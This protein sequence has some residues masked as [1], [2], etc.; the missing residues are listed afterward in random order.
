[1]RRK[2]LRVEGPASL[3]HNQETRRRESALVSPRG[4]F[5][6]RRNSLLER[7][8]HPS[9]HGRNGCRVSQSQALPFVQPIAAKKTRKSTREEAPLP[10]PPGWSAGSPPA[11]RRPRKH[12]AGPRARGAGPGGRRQQR[13]LPHAVGAGAQLLPDARQAGVEVLHQ[14]GL[15]HLVHPEHPG[16]LPA[17]P[18]ARAARPPGPGLRPPSSAGAS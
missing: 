10:S 13:P 12:A 8:G 7:K 9:R 17:S 14:P 15:D 18:P 2:K 3:P 5:H 1:M 4:Y 11:A 6:P 16:H